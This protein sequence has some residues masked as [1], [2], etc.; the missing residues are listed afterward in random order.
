MIRYL[1]I[2]IITFFSYTA[3]GSTF[4]CERIRLDSSGFSSITAAES[5]YNK[6]VTIIADINQK[7]ATFRGKTSDL[8]IRGD[9]KRLKVSFSSQMSGGKWLEQSFVFLAN[10]EVHADLSQVGGFKSAGG[11]V[12]KCSG[13]NG[14]LQ[15]NNSVSK[16]T[17][18]YSWGKNEY[19]YED[20][21][22]IFKNR[23]NKVL[24][25]LA[26]W[27]YKDK[28]QI[29]LWDKDY[30]AKYTVGSAASRYVSENNVSCKIGL[31]SDVEMEC[32]DAISRYDGEKYNIFTY[33]SNVNNEIKNNS[34]C[35]WDKK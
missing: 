10:G 22:K 29:M 34:A 9:K 33:N 8:W 14:T 11:A 3:L 17:K 25:G 1:I 20:L 16:N 35:G 19:I 30:T 2:V 5:W 13:W 24:C 23:K 7:K 27:V 18:S 31:V 12:Y 26:T 15:A 4:S 6:N 32:H 21:V 28:S